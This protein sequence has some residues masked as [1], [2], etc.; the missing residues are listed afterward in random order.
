MIRE[1]ELVLGPGDGDKQQGALV[2]QLAEGAEHGVRPYL[3]SAE[4]KLA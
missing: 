1:G 3:W 4:P 2:G